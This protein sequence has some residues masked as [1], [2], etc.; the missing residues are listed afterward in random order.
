MQSAFGGFGFQPQ[1][2][3]SH[4]LP[5][6]ARVLGDP[7]V[8]VR[9]EWGSCGIAKGNDDEKARARNSTLL[10]F[11]RRGGEAIFFKKIV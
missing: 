1:G 5:A 7:L 9:H 10:F 3:R 2:L 8:S 6:P 4:G 11:S